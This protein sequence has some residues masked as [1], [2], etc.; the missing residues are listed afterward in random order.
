MLPHTP[1]TFCVQIYFGCRGREHFP[2]LILRY[3]SCQLF[4]ETFVFCPT[5]RD[6]FFFFFAKFDIENSA[7][8]PLTMGRPQA[9][10]DRDGELE[11]A[12]R[13]AAEREDELVARVRELEA[14]L[15]KRDSSCDYLK[16]R[17]LNLD[18]HVKALERDNEKM[19]QL[20]RDEVLLF[21]TKRR[22]PTLH[23]T[24]NLY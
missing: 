24:C 22:R 14:Q 18:I 5:L 11:V 9:G 4:T 21:C 6:V 8:R 10:V 13:R 17:N 12:L 7:R 2:R 3:S 20:L 23:R 1:G 15:D 16:K 19:N